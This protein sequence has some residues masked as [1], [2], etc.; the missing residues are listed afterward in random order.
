[1]GEIAMSHFRQTAPAGVIILLTGLIGFLLGR[2]A[3]TTP[4]SV[5][6]PPTLLRACS[7]RAS[8]GDPVRAVF[9]GDY[10]VRLE[11][12][13]QGRTFVAP[14]NTLAALEAP[15]FTRCQMAHYRA[16]RNR[17]SVTLEFP[18]KAAD[19]TVAG[20]TAVY[21]FASN[22]EFRVFRLDAT[23]WFVRT[24]ANRLGQAEARPAAP[25]K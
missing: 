1:V 19:Q 12:D 23:G 16:E 14:S 8:N 18:L 25:N 10:V 6:P 15:D 4:P 17:P 20:K 5:S 9:C 11:F 7:F 22:G 2:R 21:I 24:G 3:T 13:H